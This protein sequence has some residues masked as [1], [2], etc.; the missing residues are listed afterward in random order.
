[1]RLSSERPSVRAPKGL[2]GH[3]SWP[4]GV[5]ALWLAF[6]VLLAAFAIQ[7]SA[8]A[9]TFPAPCGPTGQT[10][11]CTVYTSMFEGYDAYAP[12]GKTASQNVY[13]SMPTGWANV[14]YFG[15]AN[16]VLKSWSVLFAFR[17]PDYGQLNESAS[18]GQNFAILGGCATTVSCSTAKSR[19]LWISNPANSST[20]ASN[21]EINIALIETSVQPGTSNVNAWVSPVS[22]GSTHTGITVSPDKTYCG[23]LTQNGVD[24]VIGAGTMTLTVVDT[25]GNLIAVKNGGLNQ[26]TSGTNF[27]YVSGSVRGQ[28]GSTGINDIF[29]L[30]GSLVAGSSG[31]YASGGSVGPVGMF[32]GL[33]P[34]TASLESLCQ[35]DEDITTWASSQNLATNALYR[36]SV[37]PGSSSSAPVLAGD[38]TGTIKAAATPGGATGAVQSANPIIVPAALICADPGPDYVWSIDLPKGTAPTGTYIAH[39]TVNTAAMGGFPSAIQ[40]QVVQCDT[41]TCA[42]PSTTAGW[43]NLTLLSGTWSGTG[44][45]TA[46][47]SGIPASPNDPTRPYKISFRPANS[48][49]YVLSMPDPFF[50]GI[51]ILWGPGQ[52]QMC[53][54]LQS[55]QLENGAIVPA[56]SGMYAHIRMLPVQGTNFSYW[57]PG[58]IPNLRTMT[59]LSVPGTGGLPGVPDAIQGASTTE[60]E[61]L[62]DLASQEN[63]PVMLI[64]I[65]NSGTP[66]DAWTYGG[67]SATVT[68]PFTAGFTPQTNLTLDPTLGGQI[69]PVMFNALKWYAA[70]V[71]SFFQ[72]VKPGSVVITD[73]SGHVLATDAASACAPSAMSSTPTC[74]ASGV[75]VATGYG[76]TGISG[77]PAITYAGSSSNLPPVL[78]A[79]TWTGPV[80]GNLYVT[81]QS[82]Q[83]T[84]PG[85]YQVNQPLTSYSLWGASAVDGYV[86]A[87]LARL[88]GKPTL[89]VESQCTSNSSEIT[90]NQGGV[91][92]APYVTGEGSMLAKW[93]YVN[94]A[95][96][97]GSLIP[98]WTSTIPVLVLGFQQNPYP[99]YS[100]V[101]GQSAACRQFLFDLGSR[102]PPYNYAQP[103]LSYDKL[104][105]GT[106]CAAH[107][108]NTQHGGGRA[109][110][111]YAADIQALVDAHPG[112]A[113]GPYLDVS[114]GK[115]PCVFSSTSYAKIICT[116]TLDTVDG[117]NNLV[118]CGGVADACT[119]QAAMGTSTAIGGVRIC[120]GQAPNPRD[121]TKTFCWSYDGVDEGSQG[122]TAGTA[123]STQTFNCYLLSSNQFECDKPAG[124]APWISGQTWLTLYQDAP[125]FRAGMLKS[126]N[127]TSPGAGC[128]AGVH[129]G[130]GIDLGTGATGSGGAWTASVSTDGRGALTA[131]N[132]TNTGHD[133]SGN[134]TLDFSSLN[135]TTDPVVS[136]AAWIVTDDRNAQETM[137]FGDRGVRAPSAY[138]GTYEPGPEAQPAGL[139]YPILVAG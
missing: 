37:S 7:T 90:P 81:W 121:P 67:V 69:P 78:Q 54:V 93:A 10:A 104:C 17:A 111:K 126:L 125:F 102:G 64:P 6:A 80:S 132:T 119:N 62:N 3:A 11:P 85:M 16:D 25:A 124:A 29:S 118:T 86:N 87:T 70:F 34:T 57:T 39:C 122:E 51:S 27:Y 46:S 32:W 89:Q 84:T 97:L 48:T 58:G 129:T 88:G 73:G 96:R 116:M 103:L 49:G 42:N 50:V 23:L 19:G 65:C 36:F 47:L 76:G 1:M 130:L 79:I 40:A 5:A 72:V 4:H 92:Q 131:A 115:Q 66:I 55:N 138:Y 9:Q 117:D 114:G 43:T 127:I 61:L 77:S 8:H 106:S 112:I 33:P 71:G 12:S 135:C 133:Y 20:Q 53:E 83:D 60:Q 35:G 68:L 75:V 100:N 14:P 45:F 74:P 139:S 101:I 41:I 94:G 18:A 107:P 28:T 128:N 21:L 120:Q 99:P 13:L 24:A 59:M 30:V 22:T 31:S 105:S 136:V 95:S 15:N 98:Q 38:A 110:R 2:R 44:A 109:G 134:L 26:A 56:K 63:M 123:D 82:Q 113:L 137:I 52:S 91:Q 108:N